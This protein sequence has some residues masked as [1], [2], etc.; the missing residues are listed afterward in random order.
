ML[1]LALLSEAGSKGN[2]KNLDANQDV[3]PFTLLLQPF[4]VLIYMDT[5]V[6]RKTV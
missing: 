6:S 1:P 5:F 4:K 3:V 2:R